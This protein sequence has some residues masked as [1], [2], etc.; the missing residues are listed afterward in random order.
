MASSS[1][2]NSRLGAAVCLAV[3]FLSVAACAAPVIDGEAVAGHRS[4]QLGPPLDV[5]VVDLRTPFNQTHDEVND[6]WTDEQLNDVSPLPN[7]APPD[8]GGFTVPDPATDVIVEPTTG[9]ITGAVGP[10]PSMAGDPFDKTGLAGATQGQIFGTFGSDNYV[11][12][13][14]V[15]NSKNGLVVATAAHCVY[16]H[17]MGFADNVLFVPASDGLA[18]S[19]PYGVW[20]PESF[21]VSQHFKDEA[22]TDADGHISGDGWSQ[23]FAFMYM[24]SLNGQTL[25]EV[26]GGQGIAFGAEVGPLMVIGY[27]AAPPFDGM[28]ERYCFDDTPGIIRGTISVDCDMTGGSSGGGWL[29]GYDAA[30]GSGYV[31]AATSFGPADAPAG[32]GYLGAIG[33]GEEALKLYRAAESQ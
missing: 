22:L 14:S 3:A 2:R 19:R 21:Y 7:P 17:N 25:Q 20:I 30:A 31:I 6:Y 8:D 33:F 9:R 11:C 24:Q 5:D 1:P 28:T 13:A 29:A 10:A 12:S 26:T 18:T 32:T 16:D 15:V 23:D 27:P 4:S